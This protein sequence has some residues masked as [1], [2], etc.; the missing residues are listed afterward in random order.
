MTLQW[1]ELNKMGNHPFVSI[2]IPGNNHLCRIYRSCHD[3]GVSSGSLEKVILQDCKHLLK[4]VVG[5]KWLAIGNDATLNFW[6][7][8]PVWNHPTQVGKKKVA[9]LAT[10][11]NLKI[12]QFSGLKL[13]TALLPNLFAEKEITPWAGSQAAKQKWY[14]I[15]SLG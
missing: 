5:G 1:F 10:Q 8:P 2:T 15:S 12:C 13:P 7:H 11:K 4:Q 14:D 3:T 6:K 9:D